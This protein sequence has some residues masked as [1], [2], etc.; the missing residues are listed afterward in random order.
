MLKTDDV[1]RIA[2]GFIRKFSMPFLKKQIARVENV[3]NNIESIDP[4]IL[5][6]ALGVLG[7][8]DIGDVTSAYLAK[9]ADDIVETL[10]AVKVVKDTAEWHNAW[11]N[12]FRQ[13]VML[14]ERHLNAALLMKLE[15]LARA[16]IDG[17]ATNAGCTEDWL[18]RML[19]RIRSD[20]ECG[21]DIRLNSKT[22]LPD[23]QIGIEYVKGAHKR[24]LNEEKLQEMVV[25]T[26]IAATRTWFGLQNEFLT[27]ARSNF[28]DILMDH[29]GPGALLLPDVWDAYIDMPKWLFD[30]DV[31]YPRRT[32]LKFTPE[33]HI[34]FQRIVASTAA[35]D[36]TTQAFR[37][38]HALKLAYRGLVDRV[39]HSLE[40]IGATSAPKKRKVKLVEDDYD[41]EKEVAAG[42]SPQRGDISLAPARISLLLR[43]AAYAAEGRTDGCTSLQKHIA[44]KTD[45][46]QPLREAGVSR[47]RINGRD[48]EHLTS[49]HLCTQAGFFTLL[50][51]RNILYNS[52]YLHS[53][54]IEA[55]DRRVLFQSVKDFQEHMTT[56]AKK[57]TIKNKEAFFCNKQALSQ[58]P[59]KE[60]S[61]KAA[62]K[63]WNLSKALPLTGFSVQP[64]KFEDMRMQLEKAANNENIAGFGKL[65]RFL[66]LVDMCA[67]GVVEKPSVDEMGRCI[68]RL[69]AGGKA[70]LELLGYLD[71]TLEKPTQDEVAQ[72][73]ANYFEAASNTMTAEEREV[74]GWDTLV[75]EHTLCK[76]KRMWKQVS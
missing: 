53:A 48:G 58:R 34:T 57:Y 20:I 38:F 74:R 69:D 66:T 36:H 51:F 56:V 17:G 4:D 26:A 73:F 13:R 64:A 43:E 67:T 46:L 19:D 14:C 21:M 63:F 37:R 70:G 16:A 32:N 27:E 25:L 68:Y 44:A 42:P 12:V 61:T 33:Y 30:M 29:Y 49:T 7:R 62:T 75:S 3:T 28:V 18:Y 8:I 9:S 15:G 55:T 65:S 76:L 50:L 59:I 60:R 24:A 10:G 52:K 41:I 45:L 35:A 6:K 71:N 23:I 31:L 2:R 11:G 1:E 40:A 5:M 22:Y 72:A 47:T 54:K 39:H